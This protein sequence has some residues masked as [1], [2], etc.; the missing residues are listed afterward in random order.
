MSEPRGA[1][2]VDRPARA[3]TFQQLHGARLHA[4]A[5]LLTLGDRRMAARVTAGAIGAGLDHIDALADP[6][7]AAAW[8]R[9]HVRRAVPRRHRPRKGD[10]ALAALS[11]LRV[12]AATLSGLARLDRDER[13]ALL[14]SAVERRD[15]T[16]VAVVVGRDGRGLEDL[17]RRARRHFL[18]GHRAAASVSHEEHAGPLMSLVRETAARILS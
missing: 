2:S 3:S 9:G 8:L 7:P 14:A 1:T 6:E 10:E 17:L 4:F 5:L 15:L 16:H 18:D 13:A 11:V 12:D